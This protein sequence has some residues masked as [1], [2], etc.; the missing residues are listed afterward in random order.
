M[1][2]RSQLRH[3]FQIKGFTLI[4]S[5][6]SVAL[7]AILLGIALPSL[8]LQWQRTRRQDALHALGQLHLRQLQWRGMH[9][10]YASTLSE[11]S[12]PSGTSAAGHYTL[13]IQNAN[14]HSFDL[15][16]TAIGLQARDSPCLVVSLRLTAE[17]VVQRTSN[18]QNSDLG[19]C[20]P[21]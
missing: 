14:A 17:G 4:E 8:D 18:L 19:R 6:L 2:P 11:L 16:A 15:Q 7:V 20:W 12:W 10:Q 21:W 13:K 1:H 5:V 9:S 3:N